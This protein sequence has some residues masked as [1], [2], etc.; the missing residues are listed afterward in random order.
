MNR[1]FQKSSDEDLRAVLL[2]GGLGTRLRPV[3]SSAPKALATVGDNSFLELLVRQ[4]RHQG[5]RRL[6][7]CT[8]YLGE[9]IEEEFGDGQPWDVA[10]EYSKE[11][12]PMGTAGALKLAQP[13][14]QSEA[15][16]LV[17]NGDSFVDAD[18]P[19]LIEFHRRHDGLASMAVVQ[20]EDAARYG[21]VQLGYSGRVLGFAEKTGRAA[22]GMVNAGIYIFDRS[23]LE[24]IPEGPA[25]LERDVFPF[26]LAHG[27]YALEQK[28]M[29]I[30][31]GTP[32]D[33]ARAQGLS[34][35]LYKTALQKQECR[36][37]EG[38]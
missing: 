2:V 27:V 29:F 10:I 28:G 5:I 13:Y 31:I 18:L 7:M 35:R 26:A 12:S 6:V 37:A 30:D 1:P 9:Q 23:I 38:A 32:A 25:S 3:V 34:D 19:Q 20:V 36:D 24:F 11:L 4:L 14:L 15:D 8:G 33:Y 16:F 17:M 22:P 21:T